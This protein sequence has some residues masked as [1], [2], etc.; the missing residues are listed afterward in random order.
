M[1]QKGE[2]WNEKSP[3]FLS[4]QDIRDIRAAASTSTQVEVAKRYG[5]NSLRIARIQRRQ[6]YSHVTD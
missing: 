3:K 1:I 6:S 5:V 4:E 2:T